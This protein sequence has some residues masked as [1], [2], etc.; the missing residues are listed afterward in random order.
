MAQDKFMVNCNV[1][2]RQYQDGPHRY[3]GH[4]LKRYGNIFCCNTCWE[5]NWDGWAPHRE[6]VLLAHLK[7][8]GLPVPERNA[9]GFLPRE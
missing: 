7:A 1:C 6:P 2:G 4:G 5:T 8:K 3:E 9:K